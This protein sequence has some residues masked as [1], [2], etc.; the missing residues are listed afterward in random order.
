M[1]EIIKSEKKLLILDG[2]AFIFRA[3]LSGQAE[4]NTEFLKQCSEC[5]KYYYPKSKIDEL[6]SDHLLPEI[7]DFINSKIK[8]Q[9]DKSNEDLKCEIEGCKGLKGPVRTKIVNGF[10]SSLYK[11]IKDHKPSNII[12]ALDS[13]GGS[14]RNKLHS[15]YKANRP[16]ADPEMTAQIP[17]L[18]DMLDIH[19]IQMVSMDNYEADDVIGTIAKKSSQENINTIIASGDKDLFQLIDDR[20][21]IWYVSPFRGEA[22][23]VSKESFSDEKKF[24]GINPINV[25]DLKGIAG[26]ASDNFKGVLGVGD[27]SALALVKEFGSLEN[28]Y[29]NIEKIPDLKL[30]G[31]KRVKDLME[32]YKENAYLSKE[33]ATIF[34]DISLSIDFD[35]SIYTFP[36]IQIF[37]RGIL[38]LKRLSERTPKGGQDHIEEETSIVTGEYRTANSEGMI[39]LMISTIKKEGCFSFDTET[40]SLKPFDSQL[41]GISISVQPE[42]AWYIPIAHSDSDKNVDQNVNQDKNV[43]VGVENLKVLEN[44]EVKLT[45]EVGSSEL[46]IRD[47]LRL[48][49]GS[50]VELERL[51]GDPLDILA[52]GVPIAKGEVVMV[53]ERFGVRFTEVTSPEDTVKKL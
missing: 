51:A 23:M 34:K 39:N 29:K 28:I 12:V 30:R 47:L 32:E 21:N 6:N 38:E 25:I 26:D 22:R 42:T 1:S 18:K 7:Q 19:G 2:F 15:E 49:E 40:S 8:Q 9:S 35:D 27:K 41:V 33:L 14:F 53:G 50:V 48:N 24:E 16:P 13:P 11:L 43:Q 10:I 36:Q 46:K 3:H 37:T 52:N 17:L 45:V 5:N 31:A 4:T 44:I 20:V